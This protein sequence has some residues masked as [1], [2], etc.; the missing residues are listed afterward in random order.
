MKNKKLTKTI[1]LILTF[2]IVGFLNTFLLRTEH[3]GGWRHYVGI[4]AWLLAAIECIVLIKSLL[5]RRS[6]A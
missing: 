1:I 4:G 6:D 5:P 2:S 3:I